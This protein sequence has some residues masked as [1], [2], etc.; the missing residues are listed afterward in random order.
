MLRVGL[1]TDGTNLLQVS[2]LGFSE[3]FLVKWKDGGQWKGVWFI[4]FSDLKTPV[5]SQVNEHMQTP[6]Q[7]IDLTI[8]KN[9]TVI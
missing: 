5:G 7:R 6:I 2:V 9:F 4:Q 3:I 8:I 1:K